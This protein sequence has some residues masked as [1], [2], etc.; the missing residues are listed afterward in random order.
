MFY[1]CSSL[2]TAPELPATTLTEGC[3]YE[4]FYGC[5]KLNY[6]KMLATNIT[7]YDCFFGWLKGVEN[8]GTF[9]KHANMTSLSTGNCGIPTGWTVKDAA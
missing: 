6:I 5:T 7:G 8:I 1:G 4:M 2:T 3:Y 9:I